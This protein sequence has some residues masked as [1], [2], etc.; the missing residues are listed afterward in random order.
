MNKLFYF[1]VISFIFSSCI[2]NVK[3]RNGYD[4][5]IDHQ[6]ERLINQMTLQEKVGMIHSNSKFSSAGVPRL[7][8]PEWH[9]ADGPHG[10]REEISRDSWDPLG[11]TNDSSSYF[12]TG[13]ALAATWN[14]R[15]GLPGGTGLGRR[16]TLEREGRIVWTCH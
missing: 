15:S 3:D 2:N 16:S 10:I 14:P 12:P 8:I 6:I 4:R 11:W 13:T 1:V 5:K 7:N 9:M